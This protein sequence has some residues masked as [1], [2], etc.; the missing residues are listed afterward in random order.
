MSDVEP[1]PP[2]ASKQ[3]T[4]TT[5]KGLPFRDGVQDS[6]SDS[7]FGKDAKRTFVLSH[8]K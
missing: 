6:L 1:P 5:A 8:E 7:S 4:T 2:K 3:T